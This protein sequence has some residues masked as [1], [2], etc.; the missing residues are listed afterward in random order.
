LLGIGIEETNA[1]IGIPASI[2]SFRYRT[3]EMPDCAGLVRYWIGPGIVSFF[4]SGT[5]LIGC[6]TVR[7]SSIYKHA[8][9][10]AAWTS[11][12]DIDMDM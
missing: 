6:R 2:I 3:K 1:G 5:G 7:H 9:G 11:D 8:H 10:Q 12:L 4:N